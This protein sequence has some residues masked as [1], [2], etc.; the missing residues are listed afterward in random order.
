MTAAGPLAGKVIAVTRPRGQAETLARL[1]AA[2]GGEPLL[3]PLLEIAPAE[4]EAP[5][6]QAVE[7]LADCA[8][9]IF[10][11]PNAVDYSLPAILAHAPWPGGVT[12]A[13]VGQGTARALAAY[14]V[15]NCVAPAERFDSEA[16]LEMPALSAGQVR[17]RRVVIFRGDGG[18]ELLA[19]TL[20]ARGA[21][22][23]AVTCY[24]RFAPPE[25]FGLLLDACRD[26]RLDA[27]TISSSEG[28][29]YLMDGLGAGA[30]RWLTAVT[31]F[32]PHARIAET[33]ASLGFHHTILTEPADTGIVAGLCAYNWPSS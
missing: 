19:E 32:V 13:A 14:G 11:S 10:I 31:V 6:A 2:A 25:G 12:P 5:L 21:E 27:L 33:A 28:L 15:V 24:R 8:L 17:G 20:R 22:V 16:L 4:D 23:D 9:A 29:H 3:A 18:R 1:I 7:R 26:G 30:R